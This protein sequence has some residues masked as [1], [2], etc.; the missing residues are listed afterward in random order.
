MAMTF[1]CIRRMK[2]MNAAQLD[3]CFRSEEMQTAAEF[4]E[5]VR[6]DGK[7]EALGRRV[8]AYEKA[9]RHVSFGT[10]R[11]YA[12][13][14]ETHT[15]VIHFVSL[16]YAFLRC[17]AAGDGAVR[18]A[19]LAEAR[20]TALRLKSLAAAAEDMARNAESDGLL[21]RL[22]KEAWDNST[23]RIIHTDTVMRPLF[24]AYNKT[25]SG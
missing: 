24:E 6:I 16:F 14:T 5:D 10:Q 4:K 9:E 25:P 23:E 18:R 12:V 13:L 15:G 1:W 19:Q 3:R 8:L 20:D 21:E 22:A 17:A 2:G 11:R 7:A